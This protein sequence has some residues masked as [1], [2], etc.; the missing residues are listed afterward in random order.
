MAKIQTDQKQANSLRKWNIGMGFLHL[1]QGVAMLLLSSSFSIPVIGN[2]L[3]FDIKSQSLKP[4]AETIFNLR[5][6]PAVAA[7]LIMSAIAHFLVSTV[8]NKWYLKNLSQHINIAR[9]VEYAFSST[10]MLVII[11]MLVGIYDLAALIALVGLNA[12]MILFGWMMELHNQSTNKTDW[13]SFI[14]GCIAG[15]IPWIAIA[16]YLFAAG[17][18][19]YRAPDFVY[20]IYFSI[21]VFFNTFAINQVLQ[22]KKVGKWADYLYGEK[23]YIILSLVAKTLLAWQVFAGT[24]RPM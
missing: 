19:E 22:Y 23:A 4:V 20:W 21:F 8:L 16:I 1:S 14:F 10:L 9:W 18:G 15:I 17:E 24:L 2:F 11:A 12:S 6:G 13:T 5:I 7:F 3:N